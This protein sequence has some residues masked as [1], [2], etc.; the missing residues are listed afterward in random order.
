M[1]DVTEFNKS[2]EIQNQVVSY[3]KGKKR[4]SKD[5]SEIVVPVRIY[6]DENITHTK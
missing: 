6:S 4:N 3:E 1:S 5:R 2:T